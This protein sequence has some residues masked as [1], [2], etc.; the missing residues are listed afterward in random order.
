MPD[1]GM[2]EEE[3]SNLLMEKQARLDNQA[4]LVRRFQNASYMDKEGITM[5]TDLV[6]NTKFSFEAAFY[7]LT[8]VQLIKQIKELGQRLREGQLVLVLDKNEHNK[9]A[10]NILGPALHASQQVLLVHENRGM[11]CMHNKFAVVDEC[12]VGLSSANPTHNSARNRE[13]GLVSVNSVQVNAFSTYLCDL[14]KEAVLA[15]KP[16]GQ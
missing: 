11:N 1:L 12:V 10:I 2:E 16:T 5:W 15:Y 9:H 6:D 14:S 4:C 7:C 13:A 3:T 8:N